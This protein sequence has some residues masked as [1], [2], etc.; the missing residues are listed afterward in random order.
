MQ[1]LRGRND[2]KAWK[3]GEAGCGQ[4]AGVTDVGCTWPCGVW[5]TPARSWTLFWVIREAVGELKK[6]FNFRM[7]F[8]LTE[9]LHI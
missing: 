6:Y 2:F 3:Q 5:A 8:G 9:K 7:V 4:G 1:E